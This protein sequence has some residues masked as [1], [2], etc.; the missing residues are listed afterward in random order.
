[1]G[2]PNSA[3]LT[4]A[5]D[6]ED[7]EDR[8]SGQRPDHG[9]GKKNITT[10]KMAKLTSRVTLDNMREPYNCELAKFSA[11]TLLLIV[12]AM[13]WAL[14]PARAAVLTWSCDGTRTSENTKEAVT[15]GLVVNPEARVV[16]GFGIVSA[17][18]K[19]DANSV[20]FHG[21]SAYWTIA[22]SIDLV[23]GSLVATMALINPKDSK[24]DNY[25]L[26]CKPVT[27]L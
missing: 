10:C 8:G 21:A 7:G 15:I 27:P 14:L 17:V 13:A 24:I 11:V 25:D 5:H 20:S 9:G 1:M 22:G 26:I 19:I 6:A 12:L 16:T 3:T 4:Q 2:G 23:T 18:D